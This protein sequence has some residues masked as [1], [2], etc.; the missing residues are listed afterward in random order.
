MPLHMSIRPERCLFGRTDNTDLYEPGGKYHLSDPAHDP[1]EHYSLQARNC[2]SDT[3]IL[4]GLTTIQME[5]LKGLLA[6]HE[7]GHAMHMAH[8]GN[9]ATDC[10]DLMF[11]DEAP[12]PHRRAMSAYVPQPS[13]FSS[14]DHAMMRLWQP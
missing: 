6:A 11:D 10:G 4:G 3:R 5:R 7:M 1:V 12:A 14:R 2:G 13:G 9:F 8:V